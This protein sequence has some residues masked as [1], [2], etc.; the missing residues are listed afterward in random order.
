MLREPMLEERVTEDEIRAVVR[1]HGLPTVE[2][3]A[4]LV[5]ETD[6]TFHVLPLPEMGEHSA[7]KDV[8]GV[9]PRAATFGSE[10]NRPR[11]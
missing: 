4:A 7:L 1:G 9:P 10:G 6:G 5:L 11:R 2:Q 8:H 3:V